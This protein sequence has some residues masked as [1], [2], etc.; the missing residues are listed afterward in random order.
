MRTPFKKRY[1]RFMAGLVTLLLL[2]FVLYLS[3]SSKNQ[4]AFKLYWFIPDGMRAEEELFTVFKWAREG[5]LPNIKKMMEQG[6]YGYSIPDFPSHTPTN[7]AS[8]LTGAHPLVHGIADGP[9]HIQGYPLDKPSINGFSS[10]AKKVPPI[11]KILEEAGKKVVLLSIPGSTPPELKNGITIRGRWGNWGADTPALI[12]EPKEKLEERKKEGRAFRLFYLGQPL[13]VFVDKKPA[14]SWTNVPTSYSQPLETEMSTYGAVF[15]ALIQDT[16]NDNKK[17][18]NMVS[19]ALLKNQPL[20][21]LPQGKWS[22]WYPVKL[23]F[24][25]TTFDSNIKFKVIKLTEDGIFRIR[26]FFNNANRLIVDPPEVAQELTTGIGPMVDFVDN[27]PAQLI[28]EQEDK[29]TFL[30]EANMSLEWHARA[31]DFIFKTYKPD[32]FIQDTYTPNQMLESRW[33]HRYVDREN[34]DYSPQKEKDAMGD[35]LK[36]YQGLDAILGEALKHADKQTL[37]VLSSDHGIAGLHKQVKLNNFFAKKGWFRFKTDPATGVST[38]DWVNT[39]VAFL[40]MAHVFVNPNGLGGNWERGSGTEYEKL[41]N[42]VILAFKE[43]LVDKDGSKPVV[44]AVK[45]ENAPQ[46]FELPTDRIGDIVFEVK[47]GYQWLEEP[48][49]KLGVFVKPLTSGYKQANNPKDPDMWT[50]FVV[51]GPGVKKGFK[52]EKPISHV[53]QMPTILT[54]MGIRIPSYVQGKV[55]KEAIE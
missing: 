37:I 4:K 32:V 7:F 33:W 18:Y 9:M 5:K 17:N 6:A 54:L 29:Q 10:V 38:V 51:M 22:E 21:T 30:E 28:Y 16:T 11:W 55:L 47:K 13:T 1:V 46:F 45:W 42:E 19:F 14:S 44:R 3:Q 15:Y 36:M 53:D 12:F 24:K 31:T 39:R 35:I 27:W 41:R 34:P 8:L 48:D 25:E 26:M 2:V 23:K 40:K 49:E 52:L 20:V 50:P 43:E